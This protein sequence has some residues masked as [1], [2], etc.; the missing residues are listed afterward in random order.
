MKIITI[1]DHFETPLYAQLMPSNPAREQWYHDRGAHLGHDIDFELKDIGASRIAHM[2]AAGIAYQ[3]LSLTTPGA[4]A[5]E[6]DDAIRVATDANDRMA[7]AVRQWPDRFGAF[8]ALPTARPDAALAELRRA[9]TE[10]GFK[11][12]MINSHTRG[13]FL[14]GP[15]FWP[16][17]AEAERL[18]VPIYLHPN[19]PHPKAMESYFR[20][21]E[22]L[23]RP[24]WGF[25]LD[26]STHF[27]RILFSGAFDAYPRLK[28]VLGHLG[29][30]LPFAMDRLI[31]HTGYVGR[32][33]GLARS[34]ERCLHEN[35]WVTTSGNFSP[36][37]LRC[38]ID[39]LGIEKVLFSVDWPYESNL[40]ATA[41]F[42]DL[43]LSQEDR[44]RLAHHNA[45]ELLRL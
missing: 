22:D 7:V 15:F 23:A 18:D 14:D 12:A 10:L 25:L 19:Q 21:F 28:I 20:D 24:A 4:Q 38:T 43:D 40:A 34:P 3:I 33:R 8:A 29:E 41:F 13:A 45:E 2:D 37:A 35:L 31:D 6:G 5:F 9:V 26:A 36:P 11:G 16:I 27:L 30:G 1:E 17:F 42:R 44:E 39:M 32:R